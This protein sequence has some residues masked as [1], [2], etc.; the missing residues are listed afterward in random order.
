MADPKFPVLALLLCLSIWLYQFLFESRIK[1]ILEWRPLKIGVVCL[2]ILYLVIF[3]RA[4]NE[5]F[6]Y[7]Q[8]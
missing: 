7:L 2:I 5:A 4:G 8:F 3:A 1:R 6:I